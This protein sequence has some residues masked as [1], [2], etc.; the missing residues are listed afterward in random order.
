MYNYYSVF[1]YRWH[2]GVRP[3]THDGQ[4]SSTG[5]RGEETINAGGE[6]QVSDANAR[7]EQRVQ[8][9]TAAIERGNQR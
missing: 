7:R 2:A 8:P 6:A 9:D 5:A 3:E 1:V 4:G